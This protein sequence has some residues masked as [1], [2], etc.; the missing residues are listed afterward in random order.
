MFARVFVL[1]GH[2]SSFVHTN[3]LAPVFDC[4][5][6]TASSSCSSVAALAQ[7]RSSVVAPGFASSRVLSCSSGDGAF[8]DA[9]T[10]VGVFEQV[11]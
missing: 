4:L 11:Y 6:V 2:P 10:F 9:G 7:V 5:A 3:R 1:Y 8:G